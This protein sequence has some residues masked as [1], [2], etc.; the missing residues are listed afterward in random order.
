[1]P[2]VESAERFPVY[3]DRIV[4]GGIDRFVLLEW[5]TLRTGKQEDTLL[6]DGDLGDASGL[7]AAHRS[8][9]VSSPVP[10]NLQTAF[11]GYMTACMRLS[12]APAY[13]AVESMAQCAGMHLRRSLHFNRHVFLLGVRELSYAMP[14]SADDLLSGVLTS[15]VV[16][17]GITDSGAAYTVSCHLAP[18][19]CAG[20]ACGCRGAQGCASVPIASGELMLSSVSYSEQF[21]EHILRPRYQELYRRLRSASGLHPACPDYLNACMEAGGEPA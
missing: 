8:G 17:T 18:L 13:L 15:S 20:G 10:E 1:M 4:T 7:L 14:M 3:G 2:S 5:L 9:E 19:P 21:P 11:Q 6:S 12:Q 16:Q